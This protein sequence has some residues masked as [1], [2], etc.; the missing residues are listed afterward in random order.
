MCAGVLQKLKIA[1]NF[2][3]QDPSLISQSHAAMSMLELRPSA[4]PENPDLYAS[5]TLPSLSI[6][7]KDPAMKCDLP[8]QRAI[9]DLID[10]QTVEELACALGA[11][12]L[13]GEVSYYGAFGMHFTKKNWRPSS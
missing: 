10:V 5:L 9:K 3:P 11:V 6:S 13:G 1:D 12:L 8:S 2:Q 4:D 7:F